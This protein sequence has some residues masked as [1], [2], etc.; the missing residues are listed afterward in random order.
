MVYK[1]RKETTTQSLPVE[2]YIEPTFHC[3]TTVFP[4]SLLHPNS[5]HSFIPNLARD[6]GISVLGLGQI[7]SLDS[8]PQTTRQIYA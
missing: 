5:S 2:S 6:G 8:S 1:Q 3:S 7:S 4:A